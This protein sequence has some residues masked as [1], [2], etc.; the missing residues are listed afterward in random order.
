MPDTKRESGFAWADVEHWAA[1]GLISSD[2]LAAIRETLEAE[3]TGARKRPAPLEQRK[4]LNFITI[5]Y[6]FGGFMVLLAYTLFM[7]LRWQG[8]SPV[9]QAAVLAFTAGLLSA[10][11]AF[12]RRRSFP[13]AGSILLFAG[14]A[15]VPLLVYSVQNA[16]GIWPGREDFDQAYRD[17]YPRTAAA[18]ILMEVVSIAVA[19]LVLWRIH[20]PLMALLVAFWGWFLSMDLLRWTMQRVGPSSTSEWEL[21]AGSLAGLG[22]LA[23]AVYLQRRTTQDYSL[24]FYV[25]GHLLVLWNFSILAQGKEG[26]LGLLY[27]ALYVAFVVLSVVLQRRVFLV[28]GAL[29]CYIFGAY[30]AFNVFQGTLGYIFTLGATGLL[31]VLTAVAYQKYVRGRL[32]QWLHPYRLLRRSTG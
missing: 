2:Q 4:G 1:L 18:R 29:G 23:L 14:T 3:R 20:F 9:G 31:I 32:E 24:W 13:L 7:G 11:G 25:F 30:L 28:F 12:L 16:T 19:A 8:L 26:I 6:Y 5:A 10:L 17:F 15:I 22:M 21:V 27:P